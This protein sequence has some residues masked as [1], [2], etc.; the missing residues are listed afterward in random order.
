MI[1]QSHRDHAKSQARLARVKDKLQRLRQRVQRSQILFW[2]RRQA[3]LAWWQRAFRTPMSGGRWLFAR[4]KSLWSAVLTLLG[5][6]PAGCGRGRNARRDKPRFRRSYYRGLLVSEMLEQRQL[7]AVTDVA[8]L[9]G[10]HG[11]KS[12]DTRDI[13]GSDLVGSLLT[14]A[15]DVGV[16]PSTAHDQAILQQVRI[17]NA[18]AGSAFPGAL[19]VDGTSSNSGKSTASVVDTASGFAPAS[20][21]VQPEFGATYSW[22][23]QPDPTSRTVAFRIGVQSAAWA[24]SQAS[25]TATRSGESAWDLVLVHVPAS[26]DNA[27][28]TVSVDQDSGNWFLYGQAGNP[29]WTG[30]AGSTPPGGLT[31][32]TLDDWNADATWGPILFGAGSKVTSVQFG[33]G[34]SQRQSI[35]YVDYLQTSILNG[36]DR[37]D[38]GGG[39]KVVV[40][41]LAALSITVDGDNSTSITSGDIVEGVSPVPGTYRTYGVN[42]F[43]SIQSAID[44]AQPGE[45]IQLMPGTYN[46]N[47][48]V[49]K[50]LTITGPNAGVAGS[51]SRSAEASITG[52]VDVTSSA[53]VVFDGLEFRALSTPTG[54]PDGVNSKLSLRGGSNHQVK[55]SIFYSNVAGG[56]NAVSLRA[57]MVTTAV[58]GPVSVESNLFTGLSSGK[59][60]TAAW[61]RSVWSDVGNITIDG[62]TFN[63]TRTAINLENGASSSIVNNNFALAGSGISLAANPNFTFTGN[64]FNDVD[65]D[66]NGQNTTTS[67]TLSFVGNTVESGQVVTILG[68]S[69]SDNIT[70]HPTAPN[71]IRGGGGDDTITGGSGPDT[72]IYT[73]SAA[74]YTASASS[75]TGPEGTDTLSGIDIVRFT[76]GILLPVAGQDNTFDVTVSPTT[77]SVSVDAVAVAT[78]S[79]GMASQ[80]VLDGGGGSDT[81]NVV[82]QAG[83]VLPVAGMLIAGGVADNDTLN[84]TGA[85]A[86]NA[87]FN[88]TNAN[89]GSVAVPGVGTIHYTGLDPLSYTSL[90]GTLTFNFTAGNDDIAVSTSGAD[91]VLSGATIETTNVNLT[92]ITAI[93][94][95]N[96][97]GTDKVTINNSLS[98]NVTFNVAEVELNAPITGTVTGTASLVTVNNGGVIQNGVNAAA[99]GAQINVGNGTFVEDVNVNKVGLTISGAGSGS[100]TIS[101]A[102]G[103]DGATVRINA[104]NVTIE[105]VRITREGNNA[106]DW[107]NVGLN[108]AG[109]AVIGPSITGMTIQR[110]L[111]DGNRTGIDINNSSGHT[112]VNNTITNNRT[113][114][115]MRNQTNNLVVENNFITNN[116]TT[117]V[118]F[119]DGSG[120]TNTPPQ[121]ASNSS[122]RFNDISGNW[123]AQVEDRQSGGS[124]PSPGT[125]LK[126]FSANWFGAVTPSVSTVEA[127]EPGYA[128]QIP[129]VFGGTATPPAPGPGLEHIRGSAS[130]N[131]DYS[132]TLASGADTSISAGFQ[133][134]MSHL[135]T[136]AASPQVGSAG[137]IQEAINLLA[138]GSLT[139]GARLVEVTAG[140]YDEVFEVNKSATIDG[141]GAVNIVRTTGA[142]Q[143]IA[144]VNAT[145]VTIRD[146][147]I[148]VNQSNNGS[149][150]PI[151]PVGIGATPATTLNFDGLVLHNNTISS[152]GDA[153]ANWSGSPPG[154]SV[155]GAGIVLYD[156]P[157]GGIPSVTLTDNN[158]NISSG[159]SFFQ[160]AV[161]L[162]QL[163]ATVTGNIFAGAANDLI[164]QFPSG[165]S[166]LIDDNE[167][168]GAHITGG[169]GLLIGDPNSGAPVTVSNNEFNPSLLVASSIPRTSLLVNRNTAVGS[170][171]V[172]SGN[173]FNDSVTAIDIGGARDVSVTGNTFNAKANLTADSLAFTHVRVDSQTASL[174]GSTLTPINTTIDGNIFEGASGSSGT[175]IAVFNNLV[176]SNFTG[177]TIGGTTDNTYNNTGITTGVQVSGGVVN[178]QDNVANTTTAISATAGTTNLSASSLSNNTTGISASGTANLNIG[179]GNS[180]A[181]GTTGLSLSGASV[182]ITGNTLSD[183]SF[184]G[185]SGNYITLASS[186][187]DNLEINGTSAS[188]DGQTGATATLAENFDI[189]DKITHGTDDLSLGF[190]RVKAGNVFV[191][192]DSGS[193]QRGI[194]VAVATDEVHVKA[195]TYNENVTLNKSLSLL[196]ANEAIDAVTGTRVGESIVSPGAGA[197]LTFSNLSAYDAV[198]RGFEFKA[199]VGGNFNAVTGVWN[200][201]F[202]NNRSIDSAG[203]ALAIDLG[204]AG[205][206]V[207]VTA[208]GNL[209]SNAGSN[210]LQLNG[211]AGA[212]LN[213]DIQSNKIDTTVN[214]GINTSSLASATISG[215]EIENTGQQAIQVAGAN[216]GTLTINGNTITNANTSAALNRGGIRISSGTFT[217]TALIVTN[218]AITGSLNGFITTATTNSSPMI[219]TGNT[220]TSQSGA[221][222]A[223]ATGAVGFIDATGG[224]TYDGVLS[225]TASTAQLYAIEDKVNH[226]IDNSTLGFARVKAGNVYVTP[227]SFLSPATTTPSV[228][229][230]I[231]AATSGDTVHVQAGSTYTGG[232]SADAKSIT[233]SVGS[234]PAQVII[235]GDLVLD[236]NDTLLIEVDT[237]SLP[238][239][240]DNLIVNGTVD[241]TG[242]TL[243]LVENYVPVHGDNLTIVDN[244]LAD[245]VTG[246]FANTEVNLAARPAAKSITGTKWDV[247]YGGGSGNDVVLTY[248]DDADVGSDLNLTVPAINNANQ[249]AVPFTL[250]GLDNDAE[251]TLSFTDGFT[252]VT[253]YNVISSGTVDLS[254]FPDGTNHITVTMSVVD[255][256][257]NTAA[258]TPFSI[259]K[260]IIV[261]L[262]PVVVSITTDTG[263]SSTDGKTS[264]NTLFFNGTAEAGSTVAVYSGMTLL[265]TTL[266]N[267]LGN[268]SFDYTGTVILDGSYGI[269]AT[270][271]DDA[272]NTSP[273]S[274]MFLLTVE[275]IAPEILTSTGPGA[276]VE[277]LSPTGS[278][279][280]NGTITYMDYQLVQ[281]SV[282]LGVQTQTFSPAYAGP[283]IGIL[284]SFGF[285]DSFN[286]LTGEGTVDWTFTVSN[287]LIDFLAVGQVMT[288][289]RVLT[290]TDGNNP[291]K[292]DTYTLTV[293][294]TGTN[295]APVVSVISPTNLNEQTD[296]LPINASIPVA[297]TDVDLID[298]GHTASITG[299]TP[300]GV[301]GGFTLNDPALIALVT[302]GVVTKAS[303]STSGS[304]TLDFTAPYTAFNY[305]ATSEVLTLTYTLAINDGEALNN[306]GTRTFVVTITGSNDEPVISVDMGDSDAETLAETNSGLTVGGTLSVEDLDVTDEVD[307]TVLSV[308]ESGDVSGI[309]NATLL[310]MLTAGVNPVIDNASTT[311]AISWTFDS[312]LE[313]FDY[314]AVGQSLI[315]TYTLEVEDSQGATDQIEVTITITGSNDEP[316]ISVDMGDSDAETLAETNSGLT[317]GGTLSV[318]DLDVTDEVDVTVLSVVESGDVSG[319][320]NAT[321]LA[322]LTAGV[323]PVIDNASTTG[324]ISWT[325]DSGLEAFDYLAVGQS[326]ILTY[327]LEVEDSQGATDQ[328][329]V[330]ITITGSNDEPVI[331]VDMGDSD[332]ETLAETNSGLTVGG[333]LSVEDLDVT[334]EVDVTVLSV[335]ESGDVS[336]IANA[337]LLAMLTAGVNPVID[338][339]STTGAIS[340]TFDSGLEAFDY[341]AVGQSL[342]LTYTLEVEDSQGATDQIEV[343]IT[344]T[345]SNDEPVISVDMGD[346]D[347]ETLAETNSGLTVGGTLSVEDLDVTDE[348]DVTVLSVVESGDV[349]GIANA[350][351]LAMLTAGV[352]PVIDNAST[353]GAISWTFDSGLE[354]F[355]YLAVGQ[356]LI[357]TYTLEVEDSQGATDQIEVTITITG[358][359]DEPV[360]SVDM[361]DSDA[362]TLAETNSGLTVGGTLSVEDL[363]VTDEVDV[364]VL[365]VVESGDVSGIANATLL[366]M[367][368]AGVNPV[369]DNASTTGAISWTFDSGLEAFDYLAVGQ[370]LILTY[371]LEVEDSQGATDQIEVTITITGS[372]DEPVISV[373][374]GDSDAETLAETNS[375]L[376]VGGTLS[377]EDLDVT[378]EVDV[379]VLSVVESGDVSGIANA[380][381]LAMLTAGVNPVIDNASTTGAIS[382][383]FD[384]GL[385]AFDYLAVGQSLILTYT[386]EVEDSQGATDQI[387]VTITITG[388]NDEPVI[389]VD[390]GDS[391][392]ETLAETNSGLTVGGT[393]SVEDLD[394]TDEVDVTVLSVVESGDVSGIANATLLAMLT[395]GVN[396]VIDNASTTGAISWTFDSGLEAFDYLAVGQS[397]ILTYTLE[398]ED[399]QGATDQIEVTITITGSNDEPV[400]SVDMGDSDAETLAETNSGLTVGGTLSVED[401]DVTDE[402][403]VTVLS[404]VESGDVSGIANATLLAMLTAG[405]NPVIDNA[406]TT[407]AISWTFDS[408][409]EAFDYLAVGQSLIL[410]YTLEVEDSQGATDQIE[411]TITITGSNDEPVISVDMGDS[412]AET[413][414]ETNSGLTVGGTLSVEDLDVTDEVDVTVLSVVESGD[415]SGIANATL[416]AMLTAGVNPVIDNASTTGAISWTFDSGLEAFDYLAVGQS[417]ILTYT[418]EVEDSQGA[419]DQIE[420]TITITGSNDEPVISVDMG[421]SDAETLAETNSG[422]TVGGTLSVEDLDVTDEVDVTVLSVVESGD[423]SGIANATLLAMLTAGVNP[424]IDNASTTGAISWTFDSGLEAFDYLAVGQSLI[425]TYTLEVEDSQGATDQIEVTITITG[426]ND[427]PV[428]S[429]DMGDSDAET[430][431]E[432][433]SGLTVGGTLSVEDLDVTDEVDVTVLSVVESG[434]V[435]GIA[436]ATLLAMLTAGVNPV[437]DNASTTG[438]ISWTFDSGLEAFDYLAVGQSLILTYTLEV[439]DSQGATDQIE[440]TI[441]ITGS[442]DEPVI[443]VDMGDSDAETLAETNSGLTVGG[444]LSVEDLDV[445]DEV[446]VTVLSVVE[447]GDVSGIANATLLAMLTAGVNPVIDNASTTGAISWTFDSGLEAFDYLAV[448]QSLILT[449]TLEVEDSQ[450]ATDQIEVTITI[451][452]SNDEPV[453]SVDMGDSDAETLAETNSGLTVGGTLSVEDLDVTDEVDVTVLSV[454]ESGDVSGIANATLLAMLTAGVNPV[455]DNASTTGAISWTFDS[456][457][458][459]FDYLAVGQSLILTYT[460]QVSDGNGGFDT[461]TVVITINGSNDAPVA[462]DDVYSTAVNSLLNIPA[463]LGVLSNDSDVDGPSVSVTE[464]NGSPA[465]IGVPVPLTYGTLVMQANGSFLYLPNL[466]AYGLETFTYTISDGSLTDTGTVFL[467]IVA[468]NHP[469]IAIGDL[470]S[471]TKNT[472]SATFNVLANDF[473]PNLDTL[474]IVSVNGGALVGSLPLPSGATLDYNFFTELF[475]YTPA[476]NFVG[477]DSFSYVITDG[478]GGY[479]GAM[480]LVNVLAPANTAPV[481]TSPIAFNVAENTTAVGTLTA[482]DADLPAQILTYGISGGADAAKFSINPVT[483]ALSFIAAPDFENPGSAASTNVYS[484]TVQV[485]DGV[486]ITTQNLLITVTDANDNPVAV[487]D[488]ASGV[489]TGVLAFG[490]LGNDT[491]QDVPAQTLT[492]THVN[493]TPVS[494]GSSLVLA[495]GTLDVTSVTSLV[496][497][498]NFTPTAGGT[499]TFT[500]TISD[501]NG[502]TS[503]ATVTLSIAVGNIAPTAVDDVYGVA[504]LFF[505]DTVLTG[506]VLANDTDPDDPVLTSVLLTTPANG[507]VVLLA[508]G[509]FT[510]TPNANFAGVDSFTYRVLD[511]RGGIDVGT[512]TI[513]V[514]NVNDAPSGSDNTINL[515][516]TPD[517]PSTG[518]AFTAADFGFTDPNDSPAN[519]LDAVRI[520]TLATSGQIRLSGVPVTVGQVISVADINLGN[521]EFFAATNVFGAAVSSFTFQVIDDGGTAN[522]GVDEDP[523][524]NTI[525]LNVASTD[526]TAPRVS[527]IYVNS[528]LWTNTFRDF[529]DN[530]TPGVLPLDGQGVG[531]KVSKGATQTAI[532]PWININQILVKFDSNVGASLGISDFVITGVPGTRADGA[533]GSIP[534]VESI[535][536]DSLTNIATLTLNQSMDP[537]VLTLTVLSSGVHDISGNAL[538]GEWVTNSSTLSGD[539]IAGGDLAFVMHVLP[540]DVNRDGTV[541]T[542][543]SDAIPGTRFY[544]SGLYTIYGDLDGSNVINAVDRD[545]V[546]KRLTAKL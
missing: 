228:Q 264:D 399:S 151:A 20:D 290:L 163:N 66:I 502:G 71:F 35:G 171:I 322:M 500:Y 162:A 155:R 442:N 150:Q 492:I 99:A 325:F 332:A 122:F 11:W 363:D 414:A 247:N 501:G 213:I 160:R 452:G 227:N 188:F 100:T 8:A 153:P 538:D 237:P 382:W 185:Q 221:Y 449:Y 507:S 464:V 91:L 156:S 9:L 135:L 377:V 209:I 70:G 512:V 400:I 168:N 522:G 546:T 159:T 207:N 384:S 223:F 282:T 149:G 97:G 543:D 339:A 219:L 415:V 103:G 166:S 194:D 195:G 31:S 198:V 385:E 59:Y 292:T 36:G 503:M 165:A 403:D 510:Y 372:N 366:A 531:Y 281:P 54:S 222:I 423:V 269:T 388:S 180:I 291:L 481:F 144:T 314:L 299:V 214:A 457:L 28:S 86:G 109:V 391:D 216:T 250:I 454:V 253:L 355:D 157:S 296:L 178:V 439:E 386:L 313:A 446:D 349:S 356:S 429:V 410:T 342:I 297:F 537:S 412:D 471:T 136:H 128:A 289:T 44:A 505:E 215:N 141:T 350:T 206:T 117:G 374:M 175:A 205:V 295:D 475:V 187:L 239:G 304:V 129:V 4:A 32:K 394:V 532:L 232:A 433:N 364:T 428:I 397:L 272:N 302:P 545:A 235:D 106:T 417:L 55:N 211:A 490:V 164:F 257:G 183:L 279:V 3:R 416:L 21:L 152:I 15:G 81:F 326:L 544:T 407:G 383:T 534:I 212:S 23:G 348:V 344:I 120:G 438:A 133:P 236:S 74:A 241:I 306:I 142:Q 305:L 485:T 42:V 514:T 248:D 7:L 30:I 186:A 131:I 14:N 261:P 462:V 460:L 526:T 75:V 494:N 63:S 458:E 88:Y 308:V 517:V 405:V 231:D 118:L 419:T 422:L 506:N 39:P 358:S 146:L 293:T 337:T 468:A 65:T 347:A 303:G 456:G 330:T 124:L 539:G 64:H 43:S 225:G 335:V 362:E 230:A 357:L 89:D 62:N 41:G 280:H 33:L 226:S 479:S 37:I 98:Q 148:Q 40:P 448:G 173:T 509:D 16:T 542:A 323:N 331:S 436:N 52:W 24:I 288:R 121:Q 396:P 489:S 73:G 320:A 116:W 285:S 78:Y 191:T 101:G 465:A 486:T 487:N 6:S 283:P 90:G 49:N 83:A 513:T 172:I 38:F 199:S 287:A 202:V 19:L 170:A 298:I 474:T 530:P 413:L 119:I 389:S 34:S 267:G 53:G 317:V 321:L 435:S 274:A 421:D 496:S 271:T 424:V 278:S 161:W 328:I 240:Y 497:N 338:N 447:S 477:L 453:I 134:D 540:G 482:T 351:L 365:S 154:L 94:F 411:V 316:V 102:I 200:I 76:D 27:W 130:A 276:I 132:P 56:P 96:G 498:F 266:T 5:L 360:I 204:L 182:A 319:I 521:L 1:R 262:A 29:N 210:A 432:T 311:G 229:R 434:D 353:T 51:G 234:S 345:G 380:T 463:V 519:V 488:F 461:Q 427:E 307:V 201:D 249:T 258:I 346:S 69:A 406:S 112:I 108:F 179:S 61:H 208:S 369:I 401:L 217:A 536:Y 523:T 93:V 491:D 260:D 218:N 259:S 420:V 312:G 84:I 277:P 437:I 529:V 46:E 193:V 393:L 105:D 381:L 139:G 508:N 2:Q 480:V 515:T 341:L 373:D 145:N 390:M 10:A 58:T 147:N 17:V 79:T 252:T 137:K 333:T 352:N 251:A 25:F 268:W 402:V 72:A 196:G 408:G 324:A 12:D 518:Y 158:V 126:N 242:A 409:L 113:G 57:L 440:V 451:T 375:G 13:A 115:L 140:T 329:E 425:L 238:S 431:A 224:N 110:T 284:G 243:S 467:T 528:T 459:A 104:N 455:I 430:L 138:N 26:S 273:F 315:L 387:E 82:L 192:I 174:N 87:V 197:A 300:S 336:G 85:P 495:L 404:V 398:V 527:A 371:T 418:L 541:A 309:A 177:V 255:N 275:T 466:N 45:T 493:G 525:T 68:G 443:S 343:T 368:T 184:S 263:L 220:F 254:A 18:P 256:V 22:Y 450:G 392:A 77:I 445:T 476:S 359:N 376:T 483:G 50:A 95:N 318:E 176:G 469:P 470:V 378:D 114:M 444:T 270:A 244:D 233:L 301:T 190:V 426:S 334:D 473:D 92:G 395:A 478:N 367:L 310:A 203:N 286:S 48:T 294:I 245:A 265:G 472:A 441:T 340:W 127:G 189:E 181:G 520:T 327:T 504:P 379:T 516:E 499:Q 246:E 167:F 111:I 533:T 60:D 123:Y 125:N 484:V 107:N 169:G 524:P 80:L 354:A 511:G 535:S 361:G 67:M 370:S 47:L 143:I